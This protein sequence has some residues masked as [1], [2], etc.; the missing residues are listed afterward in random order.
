M[1][2]EF[3]ERVKS[4]HVGKKRRKNTIFCFGDMNLVRPFLGQK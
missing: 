2:K 4:E 3:I 1:E